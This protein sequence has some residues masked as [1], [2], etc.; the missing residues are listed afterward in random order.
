MNDYEATKEYAAAV[1]QDAWLLKRAGASDKQ[2]RN[3]VDFKLP[4]DFNP[5]HSLFNLYYKTARTNYNTNSAKKMTEHPVYEMHRN[6]I[7]QM[8]EQNWYCLR[9]R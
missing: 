3:Y 4:Y 9:W 8:V 6:N 1:G 2:V 5:T 7:R